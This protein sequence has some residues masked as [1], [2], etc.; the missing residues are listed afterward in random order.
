MLQIAN[1]LIGF[2]PMGVMERSYYNALVSAFAGGLT[3]ERCCE[4]ISRVWYCEDTIGSITPDGSICY[5]SL[6]ADARHAHHAEI[7]AD[8]LFAGQVPP[9]GTIAI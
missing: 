6:S 9:I 8:P 3:I 2:I 7:S 5:G 4:I 1:N